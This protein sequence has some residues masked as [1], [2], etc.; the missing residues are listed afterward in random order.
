M[1]ENVR[2][3]DLEVKFVKLDRTLQIVNYLIS[4]D[5]WGVNWYSLEDWREVVSRCYWD[6]CFDVVL[7][8]WVMNNR[9]VR[10]EIGDFWDGDFVSGV[11]LIG[12]EV[13]M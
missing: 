5:D 11:C 1:K 7:G 2:N 4:I 10:C 12:K 6:S 3:W 8:L 13:N 9:L